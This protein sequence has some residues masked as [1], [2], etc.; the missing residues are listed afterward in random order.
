MS[1]ETTQTDA[2]TNVES[3]PQTEDNAEVTSAPEAETE[4]PSNVEEAPEEAVDEESVQSSQQEESPP[5]DGGEERKPSRA[6]RR[7]QGLVAKIKEQREILER[8]QTPGPEDWRSQRRE[9]LISP[10]EYQEGIDPKVLEQRIEQR[11]AQTVQQSLARQKQMDAYR[12]QIEAHQQDLQAVVEQYPDFAE[13]PVLEE[14]FLD[15]YQDANYVNGGFVPRKSPSEIAAKLMRIKETVAT[16]SAAEVS[17]KMAKHAADQA[18]TP[19]A[20][21]V[22]ERNY[23][24]EEVYKRARDSRG[25]TDTWAEYLKKT[26]LASLK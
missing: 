13:D 3:T 14:A 24:A 22:E 26:G 1:E 23:E 18:V 5:S 10:E 12:G 25:N 15:A 11:V 7:I 4:A 17:G 21:E 8:L 16:K 6:E 19:R 9:P 20:S 2:N